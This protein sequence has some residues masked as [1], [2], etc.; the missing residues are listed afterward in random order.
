MRALS[1]STIHSCPNVRYLAEDRNGKFCKLE[2]KCIPQHRVECMHAVVFFAPI[3]RVNDP[4]C[5]VQRGSSSFLTM[6]ILRGALERAR[7]PV[8]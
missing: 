2:A 1:L 4:A 6:P 8:D 3:G 5:F 7:V